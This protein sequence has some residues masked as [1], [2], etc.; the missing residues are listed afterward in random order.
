MS[1]YQCDICNIKYTNKKELAS[2]KHIHDSIVTNHK[3]THCEKYFSTKYYLQ[4]HID[5]CK[6][7]PIH[8]HIAQQK[9]EHT[10]REDKLKSDIMSMN[11]KQL[12]LQEIMKKFQENMINNI[13]LINNINNLNGF[14]NQIPSITMPINIYGDV[15]INSTTNNTIT[16]IVNKFG[17]EVPI[18]QLLS[19]RQK[20]HIVQQG[21]NAVSKLTRYKHFNPALPE[22]HN[23]YLDQKKHTTAMIFDGEGFVKIPFDDIVNYIIFKSHS[24]ICKILTDPAIKLNSNQKRNINLLIKK[25]SENNPDTKEMIEEDL[26]IIMYENKDLVINTFKVIMKKLK[27][28]KQIVSLDINSIDNN[29]NITTG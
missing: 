10:A 16:N 9:I 21:G 5:K 19:V 17:T 15:H 6:E 8:K 29:A 20:E 12:Q 27:E 28:E 13:A 7:T 4:K 25:L 3:C 24:D 18:E 14:N 1:L 2:H 23:M 22:N 11:L 26:R